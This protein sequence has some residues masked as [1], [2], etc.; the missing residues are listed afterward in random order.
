MPLGEGEY[1][2]GSNS[3]LLNKLAVIA[4]AFDLTGDQRYRDGVL[5]GLDY[6]FGRNALNQSYVTGYGAHHSHN[7][8]SRLYGH[9]I[10]PALP[11]PPAGAIAGGPNTGLEDPKASRLLIDRTA[12]PPRPPAPQLCYLDDIESWSTNEVAINWNA[13]LAWVVSFAAD[14]PV[15]AAS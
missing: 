7:Q 12:D 15:A 8:H 11:E 6:I 14:Q 4:T 13:A 10:D 5:E 2:W 9:Q 3:V 1:S